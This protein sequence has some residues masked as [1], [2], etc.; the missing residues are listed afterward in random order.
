MSHDFSPRV[1]EIV[2]N[3]DLEEKAGQMDLALATTLPRFLGLEENEYYDSLR[4]MGFSE[5]I[6]QFL[7]HLEHFKVVDREGKF[8][9]REALRM[10]KGNFGLIW[11]LCQAGSA[12]QNAKNANKLQK[13]FNNNSQ[14]G[15]PVL[16]AEE[17]LHGLVAKEATIFPQAIG[18]ASSWSPELIYSIGHAVSTEARMRGANLIFSPVLDICIDPRWG[19]CEETFGEDPYLV[20]CLGAAMVKGLQDGGVAATPKHFC[21][22]GSV[23]GGRDSNNNYISK[24]E[25]YEIHLPPFRAAIAAGAQAIMCAYHT[26]EGLP[27]SANHALLSSILHEELGFTG[28]VVS[29]AG[30]IEDLARKYRIANDFKEAIQLAVTAGVDCHNNG[31]DFQG[32]LIEL[33]KDGKISEFQVDQA[34]A[35]IVKAKEDLGQIDHPFVIWNEA[36]YQAELKKHKELALDAARK[37]I[38][39]LK[40]RNSLL[41]ISDNFRK[42][43]VVGPNADEPRHQLGDYS[44]SNDKVVT[45]LEGIRNN[46][47]TNVEV[48]FMRGCSILK[49]DKDG[50]IDVLKAATSADLIVAVVGEN[51][52][53][54]LEA[55]SGEGNDRA[56]I[57]LP[58]VQKR[59]LAILHRSKHP[60]V[61]VLINGRPL[62]TPWLVQKAD[63]ILEGWYPGMEGGEAIGE[64]LFG[65]VN[66]S[67][68]LPISI[69]YASSQ[70]PNPYNRMPSTR[71]FAY[72]DMS[73]YPLYPF[74]FGLNYTSFEYSGLRL[75]VT[76]MAPDPVVELEFKLKNTGTFPGEE[77]VQIYLHDTV[78]SV[79]VPVKR[80]CAFQRIKLSQGESKQIKMTLQRDAFALLDKALNW[81]VEPGEF[82]IMV[83]KSSEEIM[84]RQAVRL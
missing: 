42:I 71:N 59:L 73:A 84:L 18:L 43:L 5:D 55:I 13:L 19:R 33:V 70:L 48:G 75:Y 32:H 60:L 50:G 47:P 67:G 46:A 25:L 24:R 63:V 49:M 3:L 41:P 82:E 83:G 61:V 35:K 79:V 62:A 40:N 53:F 56:D 52:S 37:S 26:F 27:C 20:S 17:G 22:H 14:S 66:L 1:I 64:I 21:G 9:R 78:S 77:I 11:G 28:F 16:V 39:L 10:V 51:S 57:D 30:S 68:K 44:P 72:R 7:I 4:S 6:I 23:C 31:P 45:V 69:P 12:R 76:R 54:G 81:V 15:L 74:G 29:D 2:S 38:V 36:K 8:S 65:K 58:V 34:V 80:L